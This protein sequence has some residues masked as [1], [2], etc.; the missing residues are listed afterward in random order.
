[1]S[2]SVL[3]LIGTACRL[4]IL[5]SF[6]FSWSLTCCHPLGH[7]FMWS[8]GRYHFLFY[9]IYFSICALSCWPYF[10]YGICFESSQYYFAF[11]VSSQLVCFTCL[12]DN[13]TLVFTWW[14]PSG[15]SDSSVGPGPSMGGEYGR[16]QPPS[17]PCWKTK[18]QQPPLCS[19]CRDEARQEKEGGEQKK[20]QSQ[21]GVGEERGYSTATKFTRFPFTLR[22][23]T[24]V[25]PRTSLT[26]T[27]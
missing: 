2:W 1:M 21:V 9:F 12:Y 26:I 15:V 10:S 14:Q 13:F 18:W 20:N 16:G 27:Y 25:T 23:G 19:F 5:I 22:M 8:L 11:D 17:C 7:N 6:C 3:W 4:A 24:R